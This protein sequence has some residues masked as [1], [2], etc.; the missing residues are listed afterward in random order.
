MHAGLTRDWFETLLGPQCYHQ[1]H[2]HKIHILIQAGGK[3]VNEDATLQTLG[4]GL[5]RIWLGG[6]VVSLPIEQASA[7]FT[8][9]LS[10][11]PIPLEP[12]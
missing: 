11:P 10:P 12:L 5:A 4:K 8:I 1:S 7:A 2:T 9:T 3:A 6:T